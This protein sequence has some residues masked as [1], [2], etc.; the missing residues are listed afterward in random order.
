MVLSTSTTLLALILLLSGNDGFILEAPQHGPQRSISSTLHNIHEDHFRFVGY[1]ARISR[2]QRN[3]RNVRVYA[4]KSTGGGSKLTSDKVNEMAAFLAVQLLEKTLMANMGASPPS[5]DEK[6]MASTSKKKEPEKPSV[7]TN[8]EKDDDDLDSLFEEPKLAATKTTPKEKTTAT[9][10]ATKSISVEEKELPPSSSSEDDDDDIE[11]AVLD[12]A[13]DMDEYDSQGMKSSNNDVGEKTKEN[14]DD[15]NVS[16]PPETPEGEEEP[17]VAVETEKEASATTTEE[18]IQVVDSIL[19][20]DLLPDIISKDFGKPLDVLMSNVPPLR[21][22]SIPKAKPISSQLDDDEKSDICETITKE[23]SNESENES[24]DASIIETASHDS[25]SNDIE[26]EDGKG[27]EEK[28][29]DSEESTHNEEIVK[30]IKKEQQ[31]ARQEML[32]ARLISEKTAWLERKALQKVTQEE[33][34]A[35]VT[36]AAENEKVAEETVITHIKAEKNRET[37]RRE[38]LN[39]RLM[40]EKRARIKQNAL[41]EALKEAEAAEAAIEAAIKAE[42]EQAAKQERIEKEKAEAAKLKAEEKA[43]LE[44]ERLEAEKAEAARLRAEEKAREEEEARL[45]FEAKLKAEEDARNMAVVDEED[46]SNNAVDEEASADRDAV[47][48]QA[49]EESVEDKSEEAKSLDEEIALLAEKAESMVKEPENEDSAAAR[50][51]GPSDKPKGKFVGKFLRKVRNVVFRRRQE[52]YL[53]TDQTATVPSTLSPTG[54]AIRRAE[55][56][57][58]PKSADE[59]KKLQEKYALMDSG[60]RAFAILMD[61]GMIDASPDP[62]DPNYDSSRDDEDCDQFWLWG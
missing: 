5:T 34:A 59:E 40:S 47:E 42:Q 22:A 49:S 28:N 48:T 57:K 17:M 14:V 31:A 37:A 41:D 15:E 62:K 1:P 43:R 35:E 19:G 44:A 55:A 9:A 20:K 18:S 45:H 58:Q 61:L 36:I 38:M 50:S 33:D 26:Q 25:G 2:I 21:E 24:I 3:R 11:A 7:V 52:N 13:F 53:L 16:A 39:S 12:Q 56:L 23:V 8:P 32:S 51:G 46:L 27:K 4:G 30:T 29:N 60:D 10:A 54:S 6:E